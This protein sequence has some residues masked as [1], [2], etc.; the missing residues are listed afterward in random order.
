MGTITDTADEVFRDY[1]TEGLPSSGG[2]EPVKSDIRALFAQIESAMGLLSLGSVDV[3]KDTRAN[4]DADLAHDADSIGLVYADATD[5][6]N[7]FYVKVGASG[8]GSWTLTTILHDAIEGVA[9]PYVDAAAASAALIG[10]LARSGIN[11]F[12]QS[13]ATLDT[14]LNTSTGA[15]SAVAGDFTSEFIPVKPSTTYSFKA[16]SGRRYAIY[17]SASAGDFISGAT[18]SRNFKTPTNGAYVRIGGAT[19]AIA[20]IELE[21]GI[22]ASTTYQAYE[23]RTEIPTL[24]LSTEQAAERLFFDGELR[25]EFQVGLGS[26]PFTRVGT[27]LFN[28]AL[29]DLYDLRG[30]RLLT[31]GDFVADAAQAVGVI[32]VEPS[33]EYTCG[34]AINGVVSASSPLIYEADADGIYISQHSTATFTTGASTYFLYVNLLLTDID[35]F[36]LVEG[37][38]V[39]RLYVPYQLYYNPPALLFEARRYEGE[40][41]LVLSDSIGVGAG[42][43][44]AYPRFLAEGLGWS[45]VP[46]DDNVASATAD[47]SGTTGTRGTW[48]QSSLRPMV[49]GSSPE[50]REN[51]GVEAGNNHSISHFWNRVQYM[52]TTRTV[53]IGQGG[54]NAWGTPYGGGMIAA[55][56]TSIGDLGTQLALFQAGGKTA[57]D[58]RTTMGA[59]IRLFRELRDTY[60]G[61]PI[62]WIAAFPRVA[63]YETANKI[64]LTAADTLAGTGVNLPTY[65]EYVEEVCA[66]MGV[67]CYN[68][69]KR[70]VIDPLNATSLAADYQDATH[71]STA[72]HAKFGPDIVEF[73]LSHRL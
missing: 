62:Y 7:D 53:V 30:Y 57:V 26:L 37:S 16:G 1:E 47:S 63:Q 72:G 14:R 32:A 33:T 3:V 25:P 69:F 19:S 31:G 48:A 13:A 35:V 21:E 58:D 73:I 45:N 34:K 36:M 70:S 6:N 59:M 68:P 23:D 55:D 39:P 20:T 50:R 5:A 41:G 44:K 22:V 29:V 17:S 18:G 24:R 27:N 12:D 60:P 11:L 4:L 8:T 65:N 9:Q 61:C 54:T 49:G 15:T 42:T 10:A 38:L 28:S 2:Y 66:A 56:A 40:R 67:P 46:N 51:Y 71:P 64:G 43:T 52:D